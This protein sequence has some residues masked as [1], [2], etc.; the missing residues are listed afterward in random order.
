MRKLLPILILLPLLVACPGT[1]APE[2]NQSPTA[3]FSFSASGL[4]VSFDGSASTDQDGSIINH[5]WTFGDGTNGNGATV[6]HT[7]SAAGSFTVSLTVTDDD[8]AQDVTQQIVTV[9]APPTTGTLQGSLSFAG[10]ASFR[11]G[12]VVV[13]FEDASLRTLSSE[14]QVAGLTVQLAQPL[15]LPGSGLYRNPSLDADQT[16]ELV[17]QLSARPDVRHAEPNWLLHATAVTNDEFYSLQWHYPAMNLPAAWDITTGAAG[18]V[19]AVVDSGILWRQGDTVNSHP[20]L[21]GK[22]LPGFDFISDI[23]TAGDGDGR[24]DDPYDV[25]DSTDPTEGSTYHGTHV[26]G[27]IAAATNNGTGVAGVNWHASILPVRVLGLDGQGTFADILDGILWAAGLPVADPAVPLNPNPA[28]IINLSLGGS[29]PC[30]PMFQEVMDLAN[31]AGAILIAAAGNADVDVIGSVP[32]NC[33][34][35]IAVGATGRD[36]TRASYSNFGTTLDVMAPGGEMAT[37][38]ENGVLSLSFDDLGAADFDYWY[39]QGTS[40]AAPHVSGLASLMLALDPDLSSGQVL[41]ALTKTA[42]PLS[43]GQCQRPSA[44]ECGAGS[45]DALAALQLVQAGGIPEPEPP[46]PP[47]PIGR[48]RV[49][50]LRPAG[51]GFALAGNRDYPEPQTSY[52][53]EASAGPA[54]VVA[55]IDSNGDGTVNSGDWYGELPEQITVPAGGTLSGLNITLTPLADDASVRTF[56]ISG[57]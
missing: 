10:G 6:T 11:P 14:L 28:R 47:E 24:D 13:R 35:V 36:G 38:V 33:H 20:D 2:V 57:Q 32:A 23:G 51:D 22:V 39:Q 25:G 54:F 15:A 16:M 21:I 27:T 1:K 30:T 56:D 26:A 45:V 44:A 12:E 53:F 48:L 5:A 34:G 17:A 41:Y 8:G 9:T 7:Y 29:N 4:T 18:T 3:R 49:A 46:T 19:V 42:V 50:A 40:M 31:G 52:S 43:A 37:G 55:W